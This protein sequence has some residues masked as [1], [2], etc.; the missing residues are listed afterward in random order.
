MN[1]MAAGPMIADQ[2]LMTNGGQVR[3]VL[4]ENGSRLQ[5]S[6]GRTGSSEAGQVKVVSGLCSERVLSLLIALEALRAAPAA[7]DLR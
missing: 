2:A 1:S 7:L 3:D 6:H 4:G 5:L